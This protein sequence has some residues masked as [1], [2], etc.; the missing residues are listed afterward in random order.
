MTGLSLAAVGDILLAHKI[1]R[2][3]SDVIK[4]LTQADAITGN[5]EVVLTESEAAADKIG[6]VRVE[7]SVAQ[8]LKGAGFQV[9]NIA[10]NHSLDFGV[11]G[12]I[13][14][15]ATV[16]EYGMIS[17]GAGRNLEESLF[18]PTTVANG[19]T[20]AWIGVTTTLPVG[21]AAGPKRPGVAPIRVLTRYV[22]DSGVI[23]EAPGMAPFVETTAV[24]DDVDAVCASI[25]TA[26]AKA[27]VVVVHI[28]WGIPP[29]WVAPHQDE[30][31]QYQRPLAHQLLDAGASVVLG[32]HPHV[33]QAV[34]FYR[35]KPIFYSL[36]NFI[37]HDVLPDTAAGFGAH[38]NYR[39]ETLRT[40][41]NRLGGIAWLNWSSPTATP[42][43]KLVV[44]TLENLGEPRFASRA[45][46]EELLG[47]L[48][49]LCA[50]LNSIVGIEASGNA[51]S[52]T[53][54]PGT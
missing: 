52:L 30:L 53:F 41:W 27:D 7:P 48:K 51:W 42:S 25:M 2:S 43:V 37:M 19:Q 45:E 13:D 5:L 47:R 21:S 20:I 4:R 32:H 6:C 35:N 29:G 3:D 24:A 15:L 14:T 8:Q 16:A 12:L 22:V 39:W 40:P 9:L 17:T 33:V 50:P 31:A 38:P 34:E 36:G 23:E 18:A 49:P 44:T 28:H 26:A 10:N 11:E 54:S 46:A 1:A